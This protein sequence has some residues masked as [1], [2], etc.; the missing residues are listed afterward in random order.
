MV[1]PGGR[2][3]LHGPRHARRAGYGTTIGVLTE[4]LWWTKTFLGLR[5]D[6]TQLPRVR[7]A[8]V[9]LTMEPTSTSLFRGFDHE[10]RHARGM[11]YVELL[12][13]RGLC[14]DGVQELYVAHHDGKPAY[15]QWMTRPDD[16]ERLHEHSPGRYDPLLEDEV[17]LEGAY[18][19]SAFRRMGAMA[20][21]MSQLLHI[22]AEEGFMSAI[23]YV[24][25]NNAPSLR[26]CAN[27][28]FD[29]DHVR[30][31]VRRFG[32]RRSYPKDANDHALQVWAVATTKR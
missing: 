32:R 23:T 6:L 14:E 26:G 17:L 4:Q 30:V 8:R 31:S 28:G 5:V 15:A 10:V 21:G 19:F 1:K 18:T 7:R 3:L 16:Q 25:I 22:A 29:L 13:R 20:Q 12:L 9:P 2:V 27:V 11:D 24:A